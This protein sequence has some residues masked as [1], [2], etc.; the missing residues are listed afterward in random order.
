VLCACLASCDR[1]A[2]VPAPRVVD[3]GGTRAEDAA[4]EEDDVVRLAA[5]MAQ[6]F[7]VQGTSRLPES[8]E[9]GI[10]S[11]EAHLASCQE[12]AARPGAYRVVALQAAEVLTDSIQMARAR[13]HP[14][15]AEG[16]LFLLSLGKFSKDPPRIS[17][18]AA[19]HLRNLSVRFAVKIERI[20]AGRDLVGLAIVELAAERPA[21]REEVSPFRGEFQERTTFLLPGADSLT[22]TNESGRALTDCILRVTIRND[23]GETAATCHY[24]RSWLPGQTRCARYDSGDDLGGVTVGRA[25]VSKVSSVLVD[26]WAREAC[27]PRLTMR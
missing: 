12:V 15:P 27:F 19:D 2:A 9:V 14:R 7:P 22:L 5:A 13:S 26:L 21:R 6:A 4:R 11:L 17:E 23:A 24:V 1:S 25:T 18:F 10:A 8:T 3:S 20:L 16:L